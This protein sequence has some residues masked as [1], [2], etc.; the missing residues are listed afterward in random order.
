MESE[1]INYE[2]K[3]IEAEAEIKK[4]QRELR[5]AQATNSYLSGKYDGMRNALAELAE[6]IAVNLK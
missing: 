1:V 4:L 5:E 3:Y 2:K 6:T